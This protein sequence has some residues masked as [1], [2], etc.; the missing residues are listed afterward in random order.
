MCHLPSQWASYIGF[1]TYATGAP[2][3]ANTTMGD[4][5]TGLLRPAPYASRPRFTGMAAV[6]NLGD[7]ASWTSHPFSAANTYGFGRLAW[8]GPRGGTP[9]SAEA[10][11]REWT[12]ATFGLNETVTNTVM[13]ILMDSWE[14]YE[15][16]T[17]SLGWGFS[18]DFTH[19][20]MGP[21]LRN[22]TYINAT[23]TRVGYNR[24][25]AGGYGATY[26]A[27]VS[28]KFLDVDAC[29]EELLLCFHNVPYSH[30]LTAPR[31]GN[32][33]VLEWIR[34]SHADGARRAERFVDQW[35]DLGGVAG[36]E[37]DVADTTGKTFAEMTRILRNGAADAKTFAAA[38]IGFFDNATRG[39]V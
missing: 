25:I 27:P 12:E 8:E 23:K 3:G 18:A 28:G 13:S 33:T 29:P 26:N 15:N 6:S 14:A 19:Y 24:G 20:D 2:A 10:I 30:L 38:I 11:T 32:S 5:V 7:D 34:S 16:Y 17:T 21:K 37:Q 39:G 22:A 36:W 35:Q 1:D 9:A 4:V 31:Y